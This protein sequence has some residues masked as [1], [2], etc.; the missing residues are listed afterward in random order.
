[1]GKNSA[2]KTLGKRIGNVVLHMLLGKYTNRPES[3]DHLER[4]EATYRD[5]AVKDAKKYNWNEKDKEALRKEALDFIEQ[6]AIAKY[7]D[8]NIPL[9]EAEEL[10][11]EEIEDLGI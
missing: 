2:L 9:G 5:S 3:T 7:P 11:D 6:R 4:E 10:I 1:M 8:V